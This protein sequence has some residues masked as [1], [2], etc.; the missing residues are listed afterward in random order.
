MGVFVYEIDGVR[1]AGYGDVDRS[2]AEAWAQEEA[3]KSDLN[4]RDYDGQ[5]IWDE[6]SEVKVLEASSSE[7][8]KWRESRDQARQDGVIDKDET[9]WL[10]FLVPTTHAI[11]A[12]VD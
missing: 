6:D 11:G 4:S 3:F 12:E 5:P 1:I 2:K 9:E 8:S 7:I 10:A